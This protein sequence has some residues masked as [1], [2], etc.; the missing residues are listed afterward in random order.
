MAYARSC[1]WQNITTNKRYKIDLDADGVTVLSCFGP[2]EEWQATAANLGAWPQNA[3]TEDGI[4]VATLI[5]T[6]S[7]YIE[8]DPVQPGQFATGSHPFGLTAD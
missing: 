3:T 6:A 2:V 7:Q 1:Y 5:A 8:A 4:S